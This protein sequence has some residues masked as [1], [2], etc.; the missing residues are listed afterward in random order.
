MPANWTKLDPGAGD[1]AACESVAQWARRQLGDLADAHAAVTTIL[2]DLDETWTGESADAFRERAAAFRRD[3]EDSSDAMD[4]ARRA[5]IEYG[6]VVAEIARQA[7]PVKEDLA[8]AE[9]ILEKVHSGVLFDNDAQGLEHR[10]QAEQQA[11]KD[12]KA[13]TAALAEL[14]QQRKTADEGL[15]G[16]LARVA[17]AAWEGLHCVPGPPAGAHRVSANLQVM[18]LLTKFSVGQE[19]GVVLGEDAPFVSMLK[20][21]AH[22]ESVREQVRDDLLAGNLTPGDPERYD[23][24]ISNNLGVLVNDGVNVV[25]STMAGMAPEP[26]LMDRNLPESFLGSYRVQVSVSEPLTEG[27][28]EVTYVIDNDTTI[29]SATRI[30]GSGGGHLPIVYPLMSAAEADSGSWAAQHQTVV[31]TETIFP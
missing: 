14:A 9:L 19:R 11:M 3:L 31:W 7:E 30:P 27:G 2:R 13:A 15:A 5:V 24:V 23:R 20:R 25:A 12:S 6:D 18:D 17:S 1:L 21:S 16:T 10:L 22:I 26:L 29:D 8:A 28:D 4:A